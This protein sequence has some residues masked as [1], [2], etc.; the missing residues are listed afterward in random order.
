MFVKNK[1]V[2]NSVSRSKRALFGGAKD[3]FFRFVRASKTPLFG[4]AKGQKRGSKIDK[5]FSDKYLSRSD[6]KEED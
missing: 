1:G 3:L 6:P 5:Y 2:K 4:S